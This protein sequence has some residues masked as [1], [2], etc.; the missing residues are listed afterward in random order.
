MSQP[1]EE[2]MP[3]ARC[4]W[5]NQANLIATLAKHFDLPSD[6]IAVLALPVILQA[7]APAMPDREAMKQALNEA[8]DT[9]FDIWLRAQPVCGGVQ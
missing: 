5:E 9:A 2:L 6:L 7:I 3:V 8:V 4:C 1:P